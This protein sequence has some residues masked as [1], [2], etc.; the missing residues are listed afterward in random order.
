MSSDVGRRARIQSRLARLK[1]PTGALTRTYSA[2]ACVGIGTALAVMIAASLTRA[3]WMGPPL[4]MPK[5]GPPLQDL[6][7][8]IPLDDMA[9][10][11]WLSA[12][13]GGVGVTAGLLAVRRGARPRVGFIAGTAALVVAFLTVLPPVGS[14]DSMDY[15]AF[16]RMV[17]LG[18][19]PYLMVPWDLKHMH[20]AVGVSIPWE[21]GKIP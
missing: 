3:S 16:G 7:W 10:A 11:L 14:T 21:W 19:S 13:V 12:L 17:V 4:T 18:H 5:T 20:D 6:S 2:V 1:L 8:R 9:I 15:M